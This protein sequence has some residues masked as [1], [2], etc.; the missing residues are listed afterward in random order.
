MTGGG[1]Q[2]R[3]RA[4]PGVLSCSFVNGALVVLVEPEVDAD[5]LQ[6]RVEAILAEAGERARVQ[7][8]GGFR[9]PVPLHLRSAAV[10]R[11]IA[12][13]VGAAG[14]VALAVVLAVSSSTSRVVESIVPDAPP[15][16]AGSPPSGPVVVSSRPPPAPPTTGRATSVAGVTL[17]PPVTAT[18]LPGSAVPPPSPPAVDA[19]EGLLAAP[20][21]LT[22]GGAIPS[23]A[24]V[25][26]AQVPGA[27]PAGLPGGVAPPAA[28][29]AAAV[30]A[31]APAGGAP[32]ALAAAESPSGSPA[33]GPVDPPAQGAAT[34]D[35]AGRW[36][37]AEPTQSSTAVAAGVKGRKAKARPGGREHAESRAKK[38]D[39][40]AAGRGAGGADCPPGAAED[41]P[42]E[43]GKHDK[44]GR[45]KGKHDKGGPEKGKREKGGGNGARS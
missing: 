24:I 32:I 10:A 9:P 38:K 3:V 35:L 25:P 28:P 39:G 26:I 42:R 34:G 22:P 2:A 16:R 40:G 21:G 15:V 11:E 1:V 44:G 30:P 7:V 4:L 29:G 5:A 19:L 14:L 18:R 45:E 37:E 23:A 33:P 8:V 31:G 27:A 36:A 20:A 17:A 12:P 13:V 41:K 6:S 43:K